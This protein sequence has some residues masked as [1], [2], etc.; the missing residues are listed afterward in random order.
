MAHQQTAEQF[1]TQLHTMASTKEQQHIRKFFKADDAKNRVIGVRMKHTFDTAKANTAMPLSEVQK[2]LTSPYY[3]ARIGAVSILDFKARKRLTDTERKTLYDMYM[4]NLAYINNWD[5]VDR[6]APRVVGGYLLDKPK[7]V[8][9]ALAKSP[10]LCQRRTAIV[11]PLYF[12][13]KGQPS[14]VFTIAKLLINDPEELINKA[15]G[16]TLRYAGQRDQQQ[17]LA[18][19]DTH[20]ATMP[21]VTLRYALEKQDAPTRR[22]YLALGK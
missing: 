8:L 12:A 19:L 3:E 10:E 7:D 14:E 11:A 18:F 21:R 9:Y 16:S 6:S 22:H 15:V 5:L 2:L 20:A 1:I 13:M 4:N 17:L